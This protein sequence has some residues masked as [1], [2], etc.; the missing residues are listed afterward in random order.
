MYFSVLGSR[1]DHSLIIAYAKT[2]NSKQKKPFFE[3]NSEPKSSFFSNEYGKMNI[4]FPLM[5]EYTKL[6]HL[7]FENRRLGKETSL[8]FASNHVK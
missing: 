6:A 3:Q 2:I 5:N 4:F 7:F 1:C 8:L